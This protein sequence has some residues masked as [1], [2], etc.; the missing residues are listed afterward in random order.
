MNKIVKAQMKEGVLESEELLGGRG[1]RIAH[2]LGNLPYDCPVIVTVYRNFMAGDGNV[3]G[4]ILDND[5]FTFGL[6]IIM[7][8]DKKGKGGH[9]TIKLF[10]KD[11]DADDFEKLGEWEMIRT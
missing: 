6:N 10:Y 2:G 9:P 11:D 7:R 3:S 1:S 4:W 5:F 8:I